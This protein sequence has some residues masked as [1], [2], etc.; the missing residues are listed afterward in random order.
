MCNICINLCLGE[1]EKA[2]A[3]YE[4]AVE[5]EDKDYELYIGIYEVLESKNK[6]KEGQAYLNKALEI[7]GEKTTDKIQKGR[8]HFL[9]GKNENA[10]QLLEEASKD[11]PLGFYYLFLVYD[12]MEEGEKAVENLNVYMEKEKNLDSYKLYE[13]D[14]S[15]LNKEQYTSAI[16][17]FNK[18][19][20]FDKVPNKQVIMRNLVVAYEKNLDFASA[21]EVMKAYVEAY[22]EDE[23]ARREYTFLETR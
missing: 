23:E 10:I 15:L 5:K 11:D 3:D 22:P 9:L 1:E 6:T 13:M 4:K 16:E 2:L 7:E 20:E 19:L 14:T 12:A 17:C 21:K 18:A 8:I